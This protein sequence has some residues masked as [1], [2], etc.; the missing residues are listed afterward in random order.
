MHHTLDIMK[1]KTFKG[2]FDKNFCYLIWCGDTME[3]AVIDPSVEPVEIF[4]FIE[5]HDIIISKILITHTHYD[6]ISHLDDFI[7]KYPN[8]SI[9]GYANTRKTFSSD[10]I[11]TDHND[12]ISV[13]SI[14]LTALYTPGHY[15]DCLCYWNIKEK[16][17][18]TGDTVFVGRPGRTINAYSDISELYKSIYNII[19]K[20]PLDTII[21]PGHDYGHI[22]NILLCDNITL[23]S[24][25]SCQSEKEFIHVMDNFENNRSS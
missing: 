9:Y 3:G 24:F 16:F 8:I 12:I 2:G 22:P 20:L 5:S 11:G 4:E 10:F 21:Y 13:G 19:L 23:S 14:M 25:F 7:Y 17:L 15:D 1:L 6:H 18:F